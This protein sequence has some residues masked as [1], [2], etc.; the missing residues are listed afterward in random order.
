LQYLVVEE[1]IRERWRVL[2]GGGAAYAERDR[3]AREDPG[4]AERTHG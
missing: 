4:P 3:D 1:L 2:A